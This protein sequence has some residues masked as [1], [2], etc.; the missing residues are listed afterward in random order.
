MSST[1][2]RYVTVKNQDWQRRI[3]QQRNQQDAGQP[4]EGSDQ[5][6]GKRTID[7]YLVKEYMTKTVLTMTESGTAED[8]AKVMAD[9]EQAQGYVIVLEKGRPMG[10]VTQ[11]D[12]VDKILAT[13]T[14]RKTQITNIMTSPLKTID[15]DEDL[16]TACSRMRENNIQKLP[17]VRDG[18]I[19]GVL[20][21]KDVAHKIRMYV[22][23]S[24]KDL[25]YFTPMGL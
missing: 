18:I 5:P 22:D 3:L 14:T 2:F 24:T 6:S 16:L 25:I 8:A 1:I 17:V 11:R 10:I 9:D 23:K 12:L 19:Y 20:T 21:A 15:P 4:D 7:S 13:G